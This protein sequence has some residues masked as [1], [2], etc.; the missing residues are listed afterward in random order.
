MPF[1]ASR[2]S[3]SFS[4]QNLT[5]YDT[6]K[7]LTNF[8]PNNSLSY[9]TTNDLSDLKTIENDIYIKKHHEKICVLKEVLS[10]ERKYLNDLKEI[11]D[12]I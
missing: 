12:V 11:V 5:S 2:S 9:L 1:N 6:N 7:C 4:V 3:T 10:S 8:G